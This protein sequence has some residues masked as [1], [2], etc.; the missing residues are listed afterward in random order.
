MAYRQ[1]G[2]ARER[3]SESWGQSDLDLLN[4]REKKP[5]CGGAGYKAAFK[6]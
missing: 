5:Q 1:A 4:L 3:K 6:S 2:F